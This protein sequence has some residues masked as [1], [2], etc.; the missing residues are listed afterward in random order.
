MQIIN[1]NIIKIVSDTLKLSEEEIQ[2]HCK[3]VPE[4]N[5]YYFWNPVRGGR[6]V[7]INRQGERL[8]ATSSISFEEHLKAFMEGKRN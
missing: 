1:S 5:G 8:V 3:E 2:K 6:S 4:V 7:I